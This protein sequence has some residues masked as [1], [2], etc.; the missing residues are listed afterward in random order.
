MV[1]CS[2]TQETNIT[3]LNQPVEQVDSSS[4]DIDTNNP[5]PIENEET[6]KNENNNNPNLI[7]ENSYGLKI[8]EKTNSLSLNGYFDEK[9][10]DFFMEYQIFY[11]Y[12]FNPKIN[13][14]H[15]FD[16]L[17]KIVKYRDLRT[18]D[19]NVKDYSRN[20]KYII[21]E[22]EGFK[23]LKWVDK[24]VYE[25][26]AD[27]HTIVRISGIYLDSKYQN[28]IEELVLEYNKIYPS[29]LS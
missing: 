25:W 12:D 11:G 9:D 22:I 14:A 18:Y 24:L 26:P 6:A 13:K 7:E 28:Q 17:V 29:I 5:P 4:S 16:C 10:R 15:L 1:A 27:T 8:V 2:N 3:N 21:M 20:S 23:V 19:Y